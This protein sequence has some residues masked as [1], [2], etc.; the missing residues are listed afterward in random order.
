MGR[1]RRHL[2]LPARRPGRLERAARRRGRR[3]P[4]VRLDLQRLPGLAR[5]GRDRGLAG[6]DRGRRLRREQGRVRA[7]GRGG[8]PRPV[9]AAPRR[10]AL[11]PARQR[12]PP[13]VVG[14]AYRARR[15]GPRPRRP[16]PHRPAHR[17]PRPRGVHPRPR[18]GAHARSLQRDGARRPDDDARGARGRRRRDGLRRPPGLGARRG[19]AG[20]GGRGLDRGPAVDPRGGGAGDVPDR[21]VAGRGGGPALPPGAEEVAL[22]WA[23]QRAGRPDVEGDAWLSEHAATGL[24][25][26]REREVLAALAR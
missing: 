3:A 24:P 6:V 14:R 18:R 8:A 10:P 15:R 4:L 22:G 23:W 17:R 13:A 11:R 12:L 5:R 25:P 20:R 7:R 2:R 26:E 1:R 19:A 9:R 21:R 16:R